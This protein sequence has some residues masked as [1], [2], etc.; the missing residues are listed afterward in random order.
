METFLHRPMFDRGAPLLSLSSPRC[1]QPIFPHFLP[2]KSWNQ[3]S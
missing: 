3:T 2:S 1:V